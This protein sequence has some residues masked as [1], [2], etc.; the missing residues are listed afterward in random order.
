MHAA[1]ELGYP[2]QDLNGYFTEGNNANYAP[3]FLDRKIL[4]FIL[5]VFFV[6]W[7]I[8]SG[9]CAH[10][11]AGFDTIYYPIKNGRRF[12]VYASFIEEAMLNL[13]KT[14]TIRQF[15]YVKKVGQKRN[16]YITI[17]LN[18]QD[19]FFCENEQHLFWCQKIKRF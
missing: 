7:P 3:F 1:N 8:F 12:G 17:F 2:R 16:F 18:V 4:F 5:S 10:L 14:I 19:Y 11:L 6:K 9:K 15:A 13:E